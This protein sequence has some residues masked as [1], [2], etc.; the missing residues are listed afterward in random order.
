M[1]E[2]YNDTYKLEGT[3]SFWDDGMLTCMGLMIYSLGLY[4]ADSLLNHVYYL[5]V[6][7]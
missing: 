3:F 5:I 4:M 6:F 1:I 2:V 7:Q